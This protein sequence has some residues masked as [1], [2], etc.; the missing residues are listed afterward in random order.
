MNHKLLLGKISKRLFTA[1]LTSAVSFGAVIYDSGVTAMNA[2]N[3][4]QIGGL[5]R[6]GVPSNWSAPKDFP[7]VL[8]PSTSYRYETFNI[9]LSPFPYLQISFDDISG[10]A[11]TFASGYLN[12]YNPNSTALNRGLDVNYLGDAGGSGNYFGTDPRAFQVLVPSPAANHLVVVVND[13]SGI[14]NALGRDFRILVEGFYDTNF[15]DKTPPV[16]EPSTTVLSG[17][18]FIAAAFVVYRRKRKVRL[19]S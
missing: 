2:T 9:P 1:F 8:N 10:T 13:A 17:I 18:G 11:Y 12:S 19:L 16:P 4:I 3:P 6:S 5:S 7:G 15:N 14:T